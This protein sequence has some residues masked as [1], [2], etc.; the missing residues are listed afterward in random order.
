MTH[1]IRNIPM[2]DVTEEQLLQDIEALQAIAKRNHP[3]SPKG[4]LANRT[5]RMFYAEMARRSS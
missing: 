3:D 5:L 2:S 1:P 4:E